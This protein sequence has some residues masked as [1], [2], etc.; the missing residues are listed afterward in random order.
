MLGDK[1][2]RKGHRGRCKKR[3]KESH[4]PETPKNSLVVGGEE[5]GGRAVTSGGNIKRVVY[6]ER[7]ERERRSIRSVQE[8]EEERHIGTAKAAL[9]VIHAC[10]CSCGMGG[11]GERV[12][13]WEGRLLVPKADRRFPRKRS[14]IMKSGEIWER[15]CPFCRRGTKP[16]LLPMY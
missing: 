12:N 10:V 6:Q 15:R 2:G 8:G 4:L 13:K 11:E 3:E 14:S 16:S 1:E 9:R 7:R 5:K